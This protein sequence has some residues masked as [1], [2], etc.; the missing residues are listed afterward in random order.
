MQQI[1]ILHTIIY[2]S[3]FTHPGEKM[4]GPIIA[5]ADTLT[6]EERHRYESIY[7]GLCDKL[8]E[9]FGVY[10]RMLLSYDLT[11]V[12]ILLSSLYD[13]EEKSELKRCPV[14]PAKKKLHTTTAYTDYGADM[15][16]ALAYFKAIDDW[17]DDKKK[18]KLHLANKLKPFY[19]EIKT[20]YPRQCLAMEKELEQINHFENKDTSNPDGGANAFGRLLAE[21]FI[22]SDDYWNYDLYRIGYGLGR[23]IYLADA[24]IDLQDD[25]KNGC[26]NPLL[27]LNKQPEEMRQFLTILLGEASASFEALPLEKDIGI[28][29][30][31]IYSGIWIKYNQGIEKQKNPTD[32]KESE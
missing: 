3:V 27:I 20:R 23:Y 1:K 22:T 12:I 9:K 10:A 16:V 31:I 4:F 6:D 26:Y 28:L 19:N 8:R 25:I 24:S 2:K 32:N 14:H 30:S 11:F 29:K 15:T 5:N 13:A 17:H 18:S 7:C 21:I